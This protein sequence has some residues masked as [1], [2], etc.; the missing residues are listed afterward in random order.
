MVDAHQLDQ[1][2]AELKAPLPTS[3]FE[4]PAEV[5]RR[6]AN[7]L[8]LLLTAEKARIVPKG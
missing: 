7:C 4:E 3:L 1:A 8:I 2:I 6:V 5:Y